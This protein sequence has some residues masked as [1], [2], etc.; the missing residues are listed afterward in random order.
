MSNEALGSIR[1]VIIESLATMIGT[2][3][4]YLE[5]SI[6]KI[7]KNEAGS[8]FISGTFRKLEFLDEEKGSFDIEL[9]KELEIESIEVFS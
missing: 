7:N 6:K 3:R 5:V 4:G 2:T 9:N 8:Y 1:D